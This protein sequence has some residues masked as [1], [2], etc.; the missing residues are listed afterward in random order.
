[1]GRIKSQ[2]GKSPTIGRGGRGGKAGV[3]STTT[4]Q[5][6][7][8]L[9]KR[10]HPTS[11]SWKKKVD[12]NNLIPKC[13]RVKQANESEARLMET[14]VNDG[15]ATS[16]VGDRGVLTIGAGIREDTELSRTPSGDALAIEV[17]A[18]DIEGTDD[19][20]SSSTHVQNE[21][22]TLFPGGLTNLSFLPSF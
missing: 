6:K 13:K 19:S 20:F 8:G 16:S 17:N 15:G 3:G 11:S 18:V 14:G 2:V 4:S 12:Q 21:M 9:L 7:A 10:K 5:V 1:M 22:T